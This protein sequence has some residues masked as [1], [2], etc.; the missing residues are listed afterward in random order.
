MCGLIGLAS[1]EAHKA[2]QKR[3]DI[4]SEGLYN[5]ALRGSQSTGVAA[6]RKGEEKGA[7]PFVYKRAI[8]AADF[9]QLSAFTRL[10]TDLDEYSAVIGHT[11]A[12]T[13]G[14]IQDRNAHPFQFDHI[15][16][17]H[18]GHINN[19]RALLSVA[20]DCPI[21]VDSAYV[22]YAMAK[23]GEKETLE[24]LQ[25]AFA[26]TWHNSKTGKLNFAR[27]DSR[28]LKWCYVNKEN[29]MYWASER[30]M[31]VSLLD[32]NEVE[33]D[34]KF[35]HLNPMRWVKFDYGDLRK[36][37][38]EHFDLR[39]S[40]SGT[41]GRTTNTPAVTGAG[42]VIP[43]NGMIAS[44]KRTLDTANKII[45]YHLQNMEK[46]SDEEVL[47]RERRFRQSSGRPST[48]KR[49]K[50]ATNL[51]KGLGI[52]YDQLVDFDAV[53]FDKY[54]NQDYGTVRGCVKNTFFGAEVQS[55][56]IGEYRDMLSAGEILCRVIGAKKASSG[57]RMLLLLERHPLYPEYVKA[58]RA[59]RLRLRINN[60]LPEEP[61]P[62]LTTLREHA[63]QKA[64]AEEGA[65]IDR[66]FFGPRGSR[67]S[68]GRFREL[69]SSGCGMCSGTVDAVGT[70]KLIWIEDSP[71]CLDCSTN[72][73]VL[74]A[75]D[76][77]IPKSLL[78]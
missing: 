63:A 37:E 57:N 48:K 55:V 21:N 30:L 14:G 16:L 42:N 33:I 6:I 41:S 43:M 25:G 49:V 22:A 31:L 1:S 59:H 77:P 52:E 4:L 5:M 65:G 34:G 23:Y 39:P 18:N 62:L 60:G 26:L 40:Y 72:P 78:C 75:N 68:E 36:F 70:D 20:D 50:T 11:R 8:A 2:V 73:Q 51:L 35:M 76:I 66:P 24:K 56:P 69:T 10:V 7:V 27:N 9:I 44:D 13:N 53:S 71:L 38:V 28:P 32:R 61:K 17:A 54:K 46:V 15:T 29:T 12:A 74:V 64:E 58:R 19:H 3:K 45:G 67:I 47:S